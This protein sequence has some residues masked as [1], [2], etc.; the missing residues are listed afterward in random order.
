MTAYSQRLVQIYYQKQ[1]A[2]LQFPGAKVEDRFF[3]FT[4]LT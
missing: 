1:M 3:M 2:Y 4:V